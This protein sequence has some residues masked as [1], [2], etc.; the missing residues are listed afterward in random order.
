MNAEVFTVEVDRNL[1]KAGISKHEQ[2]SIAFHC[3]VLPGIVGHFRADPVEE[4][5]VCIV[6]L[7][8][9]EAFNKGRGENPAT[10]VLAFEGRFVIAAGRE[11]DQRGKAAIA[12]F[13]RFAEE[14]HVFGEL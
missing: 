5:F 3:G 1:R 9:E 11:N 7:A 12:C 14:V 6:F 8:I 10:A 13:P 4:V 2:V